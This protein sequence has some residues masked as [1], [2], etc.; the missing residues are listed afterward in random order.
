[1]SYLGDTPKPAEARVGVYICHCGTNI[2]ATVDVEAV[3]EYARTL[4]HVAVAR[5]YTYMCSDP[6]QALIKEDIRAEGLDRVVV[7]SCSPLMHEGTFRRACADA[8]L[9]PF[10]FQM[11]NIREHCSWITDDRQAATHKAMS[12]VGAAVRRVVYQE[13]LESR[14]VSL[15]QSALVVGGGITGIEAALRLADAGKRVYLVER[16]PS[17][18]GHM[19]QLYKTFPT[20][21][22]AACILT[23]K[24]VAVGR[25]PNITLLTYSEVEAV[26]G[27]V[28]NFT[29][30]VRRKPRYVNEDLCNGCGTCTEKCPWKKIPSEFDLG[31]GM[32]AAIYSPFPQAV[33]R[34]PVIDTENCAYFKTGKCRACEKFCPRGAIDFEQ[35]EEHLEIEVGTIL[36]ATGFQ[37]FD[38]RRAPQYGYGRLDN[39]LT[40]LE[41]ERL[42]NTGGPTNG[43]VRL[44]DGR[45]PRKIAVIHCVGSRGDAVS[46]G[47]PH[48]YC[49]RICCM[50]SLKLSHMIREYVDA[51]VVEFYRDM[52]AFGKGYEAFYDRA[53]EHG[54]EFLR[55]D[56]DLRVEAHDGRLAVLI[57]DVYTGKPRQTLVDMVVLSTGVEPQPDQHQVGVLFGVS[58]SADGF[59]L[60]RHPKLAPVETAS[61]GIFIAGAC[62][63]P[64]DIPD[65]VAQGAAAA[66]AALSLLDAGSVFLE[67][68]TSFVVAEKCGG[69][70]TCEGL[71]PYHAVEMVEEA[72]RLVAHVN[73]VLCK[74]CGAC[75]AACPAGAAVQRGFTQMQIMAEIEGIL[76]EALR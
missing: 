73:E 38:P 44:K 74:G 6:G 37:T 25:H 42:I 4:P 28:G 18:G 72:G 51:E 64:K 65:S 54:V 70:R 48:E 40:G 23:P 11:A 52:R 32:R 68:F 20:L 59:F 53:Q 58:R 1:M 13:E 27:Y 76:Q 7:A 19:A 9:N 61:D 10:L 56:Q 26:A 60:E 5:H 3:T 67:P 69:C 29:V 50:Y 57:N 47:Q 63:G 21:D 35:K 33:P 22:C 8:G 24:M 36:L 66:A 45:P 49:S 41:M 39:V 16:E 30:T 31:L 12:L 14:S 75:V 43:V 15:Q 34:V 71:C 55:F 2:A 46:E 17:I 62:Q